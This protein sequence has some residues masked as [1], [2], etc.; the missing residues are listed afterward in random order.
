M[1]RFILPL[2]LAALFSTPVF[3]QTPSK[4]DGGFLV[5]VRDVKVWSLADSIR[6]ALDIAPELR[7]AEAEIAAREAELEQ[8]GAWPNPTID[9]RADNRPGI[10]DGSGGSNFTQLALSQPLPLRRLARQRVVAEANLDS[11]RERLRYRQLLLER[12]AARVFQALQ[13]ATAKHKLT[14][15]HMRLVAESPG[16]SRKTRADRLVRYLTPLERQRLAI[17]S[18]EA[19]QAMAIA[20]REQKKALIDFRA[21][22]A[23]PADEP[24]E[25]AAP[26]LPAAPAGLDV[27]VR[28]LEAHPSLS[29]A[30][31][32]YEAAQA[33]IAVAESQRYAVPSLNLFRERDFLAGQRRDVTGIGVSVQLP[34]WNTNNGPVAKAGAE[35]G[36]AQA[37]LAI[38]QRD[39]RSRLEQAHSQLLRLLE[40][41]ERL[42]TNLLEPARK[43][44]TLT[45]RGFAAGE[46]NVLALVDASNT[47]F[48]AH[49]RHLAL[50]QESA[51]AAADLRLAVGMTVLDS[52]KEVAP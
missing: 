44:Y 18:E 37:Q 5:Q 51:L 2:G 39:A 49:A 30:R 27:Y 21:L 46:L 13:L 19:S 23:L 31:K 16:A 50:Q 8:A 41:T 35:A 38:E 32:E 29:V 47:Y 52:Q 40:Q 26:S 20:E 42:R 36:R 12:E 9:V 28:T 15:E 25:L 17:L 10:E 48:N 7:V 34:L 6:R 45:R 22:L 4:P 24:V 14:R 3:S 33:G 43:M 11:A 1:F